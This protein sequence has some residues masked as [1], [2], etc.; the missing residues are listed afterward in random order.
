MKIDIKKIEQKKKVSVLSKSKIGIAVDTLN[1]YITL[2]FGFATADIDVLIRIN[3]INPK[4]ITYF[5]ALPIGLFSIPL[6]KKLLDKTADNFEESVYF[7]N[8]KLHKYST[9]G[10]MT[11][12]T[13]FISEGCAT[14]NAIVSNAVSN[15]FN[16]MNRSTSE[17]FFLGLASAGIG[18]CTLIGKKYNLKDYRRD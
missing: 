1:K 6:V 17:F 14:Y 16:I 15:P 13:Y 7:K 2:P 9:I 12:A 11:T 4:G 18:L 10:F 5:D 3:N 8:K